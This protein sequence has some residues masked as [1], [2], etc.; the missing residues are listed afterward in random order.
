MIVVAAGAAVAQGGQPAAVSPAVRFWE[1]ALPGTSMPEAI[2]D[3]VK[4]GT[5]TSLACLYIAVRVDL[6]LIIRRTC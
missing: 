3:L 1:Q 2:A 6:L 5:S 4:K